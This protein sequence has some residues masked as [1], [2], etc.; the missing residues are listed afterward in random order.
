MNGHR[1]KLLRKWAQYDMKEERVIG[2]QYNIMSHNI[3][4]SWMYVVVGPRAL[5]KKLKA[6]SYAN[7]RKRRSAA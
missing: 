2:R 3:K 1:A 4:H 5:Y 7:R 6:R